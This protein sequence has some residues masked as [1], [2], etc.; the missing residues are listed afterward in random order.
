MDIVFIAQGRGYIQIFSF[1]L[2]ETNSWKIAGSASKKEKRESV[3]WHNGFD[4]YRGRT[5]W[6]HQHLD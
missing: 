6:K 2:T 3:S 1:T 5:D 4:W